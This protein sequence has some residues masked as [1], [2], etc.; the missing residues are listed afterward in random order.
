MKR[1]KN[2]A[3]SIICS[4]MLITSAI[5]AVAA[6]PYAV[7]TPCMECRVGNVTMT[8]SRV[9][10]HDERFPCAPTGDGYDWYAA[11]EV[12][13]RESCDNCSYST[14]RVYTDHVFLYCNGS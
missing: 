14:S 9:Y 1:T 3:T 6:T 4:M 8:T 12:T 10:E 2:I 7:G 11:Y 13:V 5:S